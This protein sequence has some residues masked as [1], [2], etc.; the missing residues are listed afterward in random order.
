MTNPRVQLAV[1]L[2]SALVA[3][4]GWQVLLRVHPMISM[5]EEL[6]GLTQ[7]NTEQVAQLRAHARLNVTNSLVIYGALAMLAGLPVI[8][9][10]S[11]N[12]KVQGRELLGRGFGFVILATLAGGLCGLLFS[13]IGHYCDD[14]LPIGLDPLVRLSVRLVASLVP[15]VLLACLLAALFTGNM[16][17]T[18]EIFLWGLI[19]ALIASFGYALIAG[20][21]FPEENSDAVLPPGASCQLLLFFL[22]PWCIWSVIVYHMKAAE[23]AVA[24]P[25]ESSLSSV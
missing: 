8:S 24:M 2:M 17:R 5:P 12:P 20:V 25:V 11:A 19:G 18:P 9:L 22:I 1:L 3:V 13:W 4:V 10:R 6:M 16:R 21:V 15:F 23:S 14:W 7:P